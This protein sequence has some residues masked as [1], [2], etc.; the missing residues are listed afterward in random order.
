MLPQGI[1]G[2]GP[3]ALACAQALPADKLKVVSI[4]CGLGPPDIGYWGMKIPNY[5]GWTLGHTY[6]PGLIRWWMKRQAPYRL[7]L[8]DEKRLEL[9]HKDFVKE[10][11]KAK[12]KDTECFEKD[13]DL[14][15]LFMRHAKESFLQ[16]LDGPSQDGHLLAT[17]SSYRVEDIRHDLPLQLW[18]GKQDTNVPANHGVQIAARFGGKAQLRVEDET[19]LSMEVNYK[20]EILTNLV[21][22]MG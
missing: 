20:E 5:L 14:P 16:G 21:K 12:P 22:A 2:G 13:P 17:D 15:R 8:S 7:E 11:K 3:Y 4:V 10:K 9:W 6:M 18:Y 1:S 19:H